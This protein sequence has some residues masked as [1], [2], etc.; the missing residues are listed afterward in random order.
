MKSLKT[1]LIYICLFIILCISGC[2]KKSEQIYGLT[3]DDSWYE[4]I[5]LEEIVLSLEKLRVK[6]TVRV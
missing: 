3:I 5:R 4:S 1:V 2:V 6:P